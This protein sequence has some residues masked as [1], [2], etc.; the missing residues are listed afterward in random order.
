[1]P[2]RGSGR[3][4]PGETLGPRPAGPPALVAPSLR[5]TAGAGSLPQP[6]REGAVEA[7]AWRC[8]AGPGAALPGQLRAAPGLGTAAGPPGADGR[9]AR[10]C[11]A[12]SMDGVSRQ[13]C[14]QSLHLKLPHGPSHEGAPGGEVASEPVTVLGCGGLGAAAAA[15]PVGVVSEGRVAE[16]TRVFTGR[17]GL[18]G[19]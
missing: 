9:R 6:A 16:R 13:G 11:P 12:L 15:V 4:G 1:M 3:S 14:R 17:A 10:A 8:G 18:L 5:S 2:S 7:L 19:L